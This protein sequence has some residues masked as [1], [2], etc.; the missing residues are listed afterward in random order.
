M[1]V[2]C[3][4]AGS[5]QW[6]P[7]I[8]SATLL[9]ASAV[10]YSNAA[11]ALH[12]QRRDAG[13]LISRETS[14]NTSVQQESVPQARSRVSLACPISILHGAACGPRRILIVRLLFALLSS[15]QV[16]PISTG[17]HP[18]AKCEC[19][20]HTSCSDTPECQV[21]MMHHFALP[22]RRSDVGFSKRARLALTRLCAPSPWPRR[23][24]NHLLYKYEECHE[25]LCRCNSR[26]D[27]H[28]A[29]GA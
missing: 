16:I 6:R 22:Y 12:A 23:R 29:P 13:V 7:W 2:D 5:A 10:C 26:E 20:D 14:R 15:L 25:P 24:I 17:F 28:R 27:S 8:L 3:S 9:S 4:G 11:L 19:R 21:A 18:A 1:A